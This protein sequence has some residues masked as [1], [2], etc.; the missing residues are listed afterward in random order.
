MLKKAL[1]FIFFAS[2]LPAQSEAQSIDIFY[3]TGGSVNE[4][5][6]DIQEINKNEGYVRIMGTCLSAC[7]LYLGLDNY[8]VHKEA[9]FGFHGPRSPKNKLPLPKIEF[10][11]VSHLMA[12]HYPDK[13]KKWF[14]SEGRMKIDG[15]YKI[16]GLDMIKIG[17][18]PCL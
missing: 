6:Q 12:S 17:A 7:T 1:A 8:C 18:P 16:K 13:I 11:R 14:L 15:Y 9:V 2:A 4:R 5:L 10:D 3:D